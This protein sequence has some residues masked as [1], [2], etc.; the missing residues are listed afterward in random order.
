MDPIKCKQKKVYNNKDLNIYDGEVDLTLAKQ[1]PPNE[2]YAYLAREKDHMPAQ[3]ELYKLMLVI[4]TGLAKQEKWR[5]VNDPSNPPLEAFTMVL[6]KSFLY[7]SAFQRKTK[8]GTEYSMTAFAE[9]MG[10]SKTAWRERWFKKRYL[11]LSQVLQNWYEHGLYGIED[12]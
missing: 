7:P 9:E 1:I 5:I 12:R 4:V 3:K 11:L 10:I 6:I 8:G 2:L